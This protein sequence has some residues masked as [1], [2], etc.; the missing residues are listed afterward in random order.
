MV[1]LLGNIRLRDNDVIVVGPYNCLVD[2]GGAVKRPMTYEMR[3]NES[4]SSST[5]ICRE[6]CRQCL[7]KI[8]TFESCHR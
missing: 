7:Q 1:A 3:K 4:V 2:I 6:V 5:Q 8:D